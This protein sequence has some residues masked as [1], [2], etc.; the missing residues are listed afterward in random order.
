MRPVRIANTFR[1]FTAAE[2]TR[3]AKETFAKSGVRLNR[4]NNIPV[5]RRKGTVELGW[6]DLQGYSEIGIYVAV[7]VKKIGD[8]LSQAQIKRLND[9]SDCGALAFICTQQDDKPILKKWTKTE[10]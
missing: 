10:S 8:K 1:E 5:R 9:I 7:E 3:W 6:A 2:L 4:V